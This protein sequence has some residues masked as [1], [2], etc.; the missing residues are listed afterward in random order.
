[1][2][3]FLPHDGPRNVEHARDLALREPTAFRL[4]AEPPNSPDPDEPHE[5]NVTPKE[6]YRKLLTGRG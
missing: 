6:Q 5:L 3:N 2:G 1:M 4:G